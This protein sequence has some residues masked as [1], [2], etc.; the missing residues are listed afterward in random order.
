M[1]PDL[2]NC[3]K[4]LLLK[5]KNKNKQNI[6]TINTEFKHRVTWLSQLYVNKVRIY[7]CMFFMCVCVLCFFFVCCSKNNFPYFYQSGLLMSFL[8]FSKSMFILYAFGQL[9]GL[10][11]WRC[12]F[13]DVAATQLSYLMFYFLYQ[14]TQ[15]IYK[16]KK[17]NKNV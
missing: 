5:K 16:N 9:A 15:K 14:F 1:L 13:V 10:A 2:F 3:R 17:Y 4:E 6:F 11:G 8:N 12:R 7:V